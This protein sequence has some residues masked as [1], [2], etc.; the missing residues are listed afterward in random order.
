MGVN[1][2]IPTETRCEPSGGV[3]AQEGKGGGVAAQE[4]PQEGKGGGVERKG[5]VVVWHARK[6]REDK[7]LETNGT[8]RGQ[9]VT[10]TLGALGAIASTIG[11][12]LPKPS[13]IGRSMRFGRT[14]FQVYMFLI[15][16]F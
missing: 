14:L 2:R 9:A 13:G 11:R 16:L 3:A 6:E 12:S 7:C 15:C 1:L 5:R 4:G 8:I 10:G